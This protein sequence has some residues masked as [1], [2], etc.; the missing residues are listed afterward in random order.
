MGLRNGR[1]KNPV[2]FCLAF[3]ENIWYNLDY[4]ALKMCFGEGTYMKFEYL[5]LYSNGQGQLGNTEEMQFMQPEQKKQTEDYYIK[6][7]KKPPHKLVA[8]KSLNDIL[9]ILGNENWEMVGI[10][11]H[12]NRK[13]SNYS[14]YVENVHYVYV[15]KR[16][17]S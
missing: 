2:I 16:P 3:R 17:K 12:I 15:F 4:K 9:N 11:S 6:L 7:G 10:T 8:A 5:Q 13:Q 1:G 14:D